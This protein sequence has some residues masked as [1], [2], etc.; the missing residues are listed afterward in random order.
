MTVVRFSLY[1]FLTA[2]V[3][4]CGSHGLGWPSTP[5]APPTPPKA[6]NAIWPK[7]EQASCSKKRCSRSPGVHLCLDADDQCKAGD[8]RGFRAAELRTPPMGRL[9]ISN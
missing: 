2:T 5:P 1:G 7:H 4:G 3:V 9:S 6:C 8:R